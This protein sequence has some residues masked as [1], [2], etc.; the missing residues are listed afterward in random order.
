[1]RKNLR[2]IEEMGEETGNS[3]ILS[4]QERILVEADYGTLS[5]WVDCADIDLAE[6]EEN[7]LSTALW[8][9]KYP[10]DCD[11]YVRNFRKPHKQYQF[12]MEIDQIDLAAKRLTKVIQELFPDKLV[13]FS[14]A[15]RYD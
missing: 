13:E 1:M 11:L 2:I 10:I 8:D 14:E 9:C 3:S 6:E 4:K 15:N 7:L 12:L 5:V